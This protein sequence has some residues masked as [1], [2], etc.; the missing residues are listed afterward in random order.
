MIF[1]QF[2]EALHKHFE[3][4]FN[5]QH[6][7]FVTDI[8]PDALWELYL[9]SFPEGMNKV[10]RE[11]REMDCS[12]CRM[13]VKRIGAVVKLN[14]ETLELVSV[15]DFQVED[16][17]Y[18][19]VIDALKEAVTR[20]PIRDIF[21][22]K[23]KS[24]GAP[25]TRELLEGGDIRRW[26]HMSAELSLSLVDLDAEREKALVREK[27]TLLKRALEE[28]TEQSVSDCLSW[29]ADNALYRGT[30]FKKLLENFQK[31]QRDYGA[32]APEN[33]IKFLWSLIRTPLFSSTCR[34]RNSAIGTLL[35]KLS[36]GVPEEDALRF[37]EGTVMAPA[38]YQRPKTIVTESTRKAAKATLEAAGL[39]P[40]LARRFAHIED[41]SV[42]DVLWAN[43]TI[44]RQTFKDEDP[45]EAL[46]AFITAPK[47][48]VEENLPELFIEGLIA[49]L[50]STDSLE[51]L[52]DRSLSSN[53]VSLI[54]A[55]NPEALPLFKWGN[56]TSWA[57]SGNV[58]DSL[59]KEL[60][61]QKGGRVDGDFRFSIQWNDSGND[62]TDFDAH[63]RGAKNHIYYAKKANTFGSLDVDIINPRGE[64]AVENI[65]IPTASKVPNGTYT[66]YVNV[67]SSQGHREGF[68]AE[69]EFGGQI[70]SFEVN[71]RNNQAWAGG[72][73][74]IIGQA[75]FTDGEIDFTPNTRFKTSSSTSKSVEIW[76]MN[77]GT[78]IPVTTVTLSPNF[79]EGNEIGNKHYMFMLQGAVNPDTPSGFFNEFLPPNLLE[80]KKVL[81]TLGEM[82]RVDP[83]PNQ[84]SGLGFSSTIRKS[85][86]AR[87]KSGATQRVVKVLV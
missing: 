66:L 6:L 23:E 80:Y 19:Q 9:N 5:N 43:R 84:L 63:L 12:T 39:L 79:W 11:R 14:M 27:L 24:I 69:V 16:P 2:T 4:Q 64:V 76:G 29:I 34:I 18:Q 81:A 10:F 37:Y 53:L 44:A 31:I 83:D 33:K 22:S 87:I 65:I 28:L 42:K 20:V 7:L 3:E 26:H 49:N 40:S 51:I 73:Q 46:G 70:H 8:D 36:D 48:P 74:H 17:N 56:N 50:P 62:Q 35:V 45:F 32:V 47:A 15:W 38:N 55:R 75:Q 86:T 41:I 67:F 85:F 59:M 60:V 61:T 78:F 82:L 68:S 57:Y 52:F 1:Q 77:T 30:E 21:L 72:T 58:T 71:S 54:A 25:F 13:F